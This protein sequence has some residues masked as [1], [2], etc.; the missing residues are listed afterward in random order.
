MCS[1]EFQ[2]LGTGRSVKFNW[3]P[4]NFHWFPVEYHWI[5]SGIPLNFPV[6]PGSLATSD[7]SL[8]LAKSGSSWSACAKRRG[9]LAF[10]LTRRFKN[11]RFNNGVF[12]APH[13]LASL[14]FLVSLKQWNFTGYSVPPAMY[15]C[16][17]TV[18]QWKFVLLKKIVIGVPAKY[19]RFSVKFRRFSVR[20][21]LLFSGTMVSG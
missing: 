21:W 20:F 19:C 6:A 3:F 11:M 15:T 18:N 10:C 9:S 8:V 2:C 13:S 16:I 12:A 5:S 17:L 14:D 7:L 4:V 1:W